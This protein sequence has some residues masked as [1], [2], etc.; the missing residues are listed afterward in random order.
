[1]AGCCECGDEPS[2]CCATEL[3]IILSTC[4]VNFKKYF[5]VFYFILLTNSF[6]C[7][8]FGRVMRSFL[9]IGITAI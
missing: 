4:T 8:P 9:H 5:H 2:V 7:L 6:T 3:V 1:V